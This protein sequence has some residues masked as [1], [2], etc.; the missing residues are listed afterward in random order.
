MSAIVQN[1]PVWVWPLLVG[2][3]IV[4]ILATRDRRTPLLMVYTLPL[5]GFLSL[6][7]VSGFE[8]GPLVWLAFALGYGLG[9]WLGWARQG[10]RTVLK[11]ARFIEQQGEYLTGVTVMTIF[12]MNFVIGT[13]T[14]VAPD[15]L[16]TLTLPAALSMILGTAS[17][18]FGGRAL[19]VAA[20]PVDEVMPACGAG[21]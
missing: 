4:S 2:L 8:V 9:A 3:L 19:Y 14:G 21:I 16:A 15:L 20:R 12:L 18:T 6:R 11:T 5:L 10:R 17:G 7:T 1:T 13:V